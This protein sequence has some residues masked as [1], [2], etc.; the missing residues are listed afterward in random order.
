MAKPSLPMLSIE[1]IARR[2]ARGLTRH[3]M[4]HQLGVDVTTITRWELGRNR[5]KGQQA[6][7]GLRTHYGFQQT[8]LNAL[9]VDW[10]R[11]ERSRPD[12]EIW[13]YEY[14]PLH[15][16]DEYDL[17]EKLID[18]DTAM[19]P[20]IRREAEGS[21]DHWAP[22]FHAFP[23]TWK[24]LVRGGV[25][26]GYW[27]YLCLRAEEFK[28]ARTGQ[29]LETSLSLEKLDHPV[30]LDGSRS[31]RML[32]SIIALDRTFYDPVATTKLIASFVDE[33]AR[34]AAAGMFFSEICAVSYNPTEDH[35]FRALGLT[36]TGYQQPLSR[37]SLADVYYI[38]G[39][40][41]ATSGALGRNDTIAK[42]YGRRSAETPST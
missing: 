15:G 19:I 30:L 1:L 5:P 9:F 37:G 26:A 28:L 17:L 18:I 20:D 3:D 36:A 16:I 27:H 32:I 33:V 4:A 12:Y 40:N 8:E 13:G 11:S 25:I 21:V 34:L 22:I 38:S 39:T 42:L 29:L 31:Y 35:I 14:L 24:L 10:I 6:V 41:I 23:Y 7:D 2:E